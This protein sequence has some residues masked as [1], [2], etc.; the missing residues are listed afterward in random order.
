MFGLGSRDFRHLF[1][2]L[3][4]LIVFILCVLQRIAFFTLLE[5]HILGVTQRRF[6]P[7][8]TSFFG[9]L[10]PILDGLKLIKKEQ[11]LMFNVSPIIFLGATVYGF[12]L[13][14]CEFLCLPFTYYFIT[15][16]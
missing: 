2:I 16:Y 9:L 13:M 3:V 7:K 12:L 8:K 5:R 15:I 10:Q 11:I 6:G 4:I 1:F 14:F